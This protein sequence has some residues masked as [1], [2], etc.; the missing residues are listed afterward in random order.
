MGAFPS[1]DVPARSMSRIL[2][3]ALVAGVLA[4]SALLL[5]E[6]TFPVVVASALFTLIAPGISAL[7]AASYFRRASTE[8][9]LIVAIAFTT[10]AGLVELG[11]VN[12]IGGRFPFG[13]GFSLLL[14][15]GA[16][17]LAGELLRRSSGLRS[18]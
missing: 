16:T 3:H 4:A 1:H 7:V 12:L 14:S 11:L 5:L 10:V 15:F 2:L 17:G 6:Q 8:D 18:E 9:P 13:F